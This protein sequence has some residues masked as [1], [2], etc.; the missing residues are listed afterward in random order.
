MKRLVPTVV[1]AVPAAEPG[2]LPVTRVT[3]FMVAQL[4]SEDEIPACCGLERGKCLDLGRC[5]LVAL[6]S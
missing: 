4:E 3:G 5:R 1:P 2:T 6:M